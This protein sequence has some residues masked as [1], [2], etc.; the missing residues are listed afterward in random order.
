MTIKLTARQQQVLD[1]IQQNILK[2][3]FPPTRAEI[4]KTLGFK[5]PNA[6]ED[7][8]KALAKKGAIILTA[9][10]SRGIRLATTNPDSNINKEESFLEKVSQILLP[11]IGHVAAGNPI[12]AAE[13]I[14][15]EINVDPALFTQQ[16]DFL[17]KVKG[18]SMKDIGILDGDLLAVK[19]YPEARN[20]QVIVARIE[21][22]VTVKRFI[23]KTSHIELLPENPDFAP[24]IVRP[25][26][27]FTIEGI[28]VGLIRT[29]NLN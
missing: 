13:H 14:D 17:L 24:I 20:G 19:K 7:H 5:S 8:L 6:A 1:L 10:A 16:P 25:N 12:L 26:Q 18:Q 4:A 22:E 11:V 21:N 15:R 27:E 9:G 2:T 29:H 3:G 23:K 28:A